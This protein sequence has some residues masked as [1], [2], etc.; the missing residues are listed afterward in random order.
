MRKSSSIATLQ[1]KESQ[2]CH[3][4]KDGSEEGT[5]RNA[6]ALTWIRRQRRERRGKFT[7][8]GKYENEI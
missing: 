4:N 2:I 5:G 8:K 6:L 1:E 3:E 7:S